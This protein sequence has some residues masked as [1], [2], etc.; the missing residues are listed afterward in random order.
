MKILIP[1]LAAI[2]VYIGFSFIQWEFNPGRW[3]RMVRAFCVL[4]S[5]AAAAIAFI[6]L[7][8]N[9]QDKTN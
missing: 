3:G 7:M 8:M 5:A 2:V 1:L 4:F 9:E 6:Q